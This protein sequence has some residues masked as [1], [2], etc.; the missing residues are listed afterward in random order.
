MLSIIFVLLYVV[1]AACVSAHEG[2]WEL[3]DNTL[4]YLDTSL[5]LVVVSIGTGVL[6]FST[7]SDRANFSLYMAVDTIFA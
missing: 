7:Q 1:S 3:S 5:I 6:V 2:L 4:S